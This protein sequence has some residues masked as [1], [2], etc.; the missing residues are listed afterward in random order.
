M[1]VFVNNVTAETIEFLNPDVSLVTSDRVGIANI[2]PVHTLDIGSN[3]SIY[4]NSPNILIVRGGIVA[5][6][7]VGEGPLITN[8]VMT[9]DL[10]DIM[11]RGSNAAYKI[12]FFNDTSFTTTNLAGI[13]NLYPI[14]TLD[15]GSNVFINDAIGN[16]LFIANVVDGNLYYDANLIDAN[17]TG[18]YFVNS[19][20]LY[21]DGNLDTSGNF[22]SQSNIEAP[23]F[24]G[25]GKK[26]GNVYGFA[27]LQT[28]S[29]TGN[30]TDDTVHF[31]HPMSAY[32]SIGGAGFANVNP[33]NT[34]D[35]GTKF[36]VNE[37]GPNVLVV[38]GTVIAIGFYGDGNLMTSVPST[39]ELQ[40]AS[41][42]DNT[43]TNIVQ[44]TNP[45][46]SVV[47]FANVG[48]CNTDPVHSL[49]I[50]TNCYVQDTAGVDEILMV[51]GNI[52]CN[53]FRGDGRYLS[54]IP[55][56]SE[57]STFN[58]ITNIGNTTSHTVRYVNNTTSFVTESNIGI[59][60][61]FPVHSV[62]IGTNIWMDDRTLTTL[63]TSGNIESAYIIAD[64][65]QLANLSTNLENV[66]NNGNIC[67]N[68]AFFSNTIESIV[69]ESNLKSNGDCIIDSP[70]GASVI[71]GGIKPDD[72]SSNTDRISIGSEAGQFAQATHSIA[73]GSRAGNMGQGMFSVG[74]GIQAGETHQGSNAI[75]L[76]Y[77]AG[78]EGQNNFGVAIGYRSGV[79][80]QGDYSV[81][82]GTN[83][84]V[85]EQGAN[86]VA[87]GDLSAELKQGVYS[88]IIGRGT[89]ANTQGDYS[90]AI[91]HEAANVL[92]NTSSI[93]IGIAA[94][95]S[96]QGETSIAV[97][98]TAAYSNQGSNSIAIGFAAGYSTQGNNSIA[99]GNL[100]AYLEQGSN[101]IAIGHSA[102]YSSQNNNSVAIGF[103]SGK[104]FQVEQVFAIGY[105]AGIDN[106]SQ[107]ATVIGQ[108]EGSD[109][110]DVASLSIGFKAGHTSQGANS[111]SIGTFAGESQQGIDSVAIGL[112]AGRKTQG[113]RCFAIGPKAG[114]LNQTTHSIAIGSEA[115][116]TGQAEHTIVIGSN[117]NNY[118]SN[119]ITIG[120]KGG[121]NTAN[122]ILVN[123]TGQDYTPIKSDSLY[124]T[125]VRKQFEPEIRATILSHTNNNQVIG[126]NTFYM[127]E[128]GNV[129]LSANLIVTG[130]FS[131]VSSTD[132][133]IDDNI[134]L[135]ANNNLLGS[136][137]M[138]VIMH[139][140]VS[141][142]LMGYSELGEEFLF[143][144][145]DD[146]QGVAVLTP[147]GTNMK[148]HVYGS[149]E[150]DSNMSVNYN[151]DIYKNYIGR[152]SIGYDDFHSLTPSFAH[153]DHM[154]RRNYALR[155]GSGGNTFLN[156][157]TGEKISFRKND[158]EIASIDASGITG[159]FNKILSNGYMINDNEYNGS[160][161]R[162]WDL[163]A[164]VA[165]VPGTIVVRDGT[166]I[167]YAAGDIIVN[168]N[169]TADGSIICDTSQT[170]SGGDAN[171]SGNFYSNGELVQ[172]A[173]I[174]MIVL[175]SGS[176]ASVPTY[177]SL[178]DG[179]NGTPDLRDRFVV[180]AGN[181]YAP[182]A[183]G[184]SATV[185]LTSAQIQGHTHSFSYS[186][187]TLVSSTDDGGDHTHNYLFRTEETKRRRGPY[188]CWRGTQSYPTNST[189][190]H[191]HT[192]NTTMNFNI[193]T[194]NAGSSS[195]HENR[196]PYYSLCY[197]MRTS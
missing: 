145:T 109:T 2:A 140:P 107:Y 92:Q 73:I 112:E 133:T 70:L 62:D 146:N 137:D 150:G 89:G 98:N 28:A 16:K 24:I 167:A 129:Y 144:Y 55:I 86:S 12:D 6:K 195:A 163:N 82:V 141:N 52:K 172:L 84:A 190:D 36:R 57:T 156:A 179:A 90:V 41:D 26:V 197:I 4:D 136:L 114:H 25:E 63:W 31:N 193:N 45:N 101:S 194:N 183:T 176:A 69:V 187:P 72:I 46:T 58:Y 188:S 138:G 173:P 53:Y 110:K 64:G 5:T 29:A 134:L 131:T 128:T 59:A 185:S 38:D 10:N 66:M 88:V 80:G 75:A 27:N 34:L 108:Q 22:L 77:G 7:F 76:A 85:Q 95:K 91:G 100:A 97:G 157:P 1:S 20:V 186:N 178:C 42:Y 83:V 171:I 74:L 168:G 19:N 21:V 113:E 71:I 169:I 158:V 161:A 51:S 96:N 184:G 18:N 121:V 79:V 99:A 151:T 153:L 125:P 132:F 81:S 106:T 189:G 147:K 139:R 174:G 135:L 118:V 32:F 159:H 48:I 164:N 124:F 142:V 115:A 104:N 78:N 160:V 120:Y 111:T 37:N 33:V 182:G 14:H 43:T 155:A 127:D 170:M 11:S 177:W 165:A 3:I 40:A 49:D 9:S 60:N 67:T 166:G 13:H 192:F 44:F 105:Q 196:P 154:S 87:I 30:T 23:F 93:A 130:N 94:A 54:N 65:S 50:G 119:S 126:M 117:A 15:I 116:T 191:N 180:G 149:M 17:Y 152:A 123:A 175:W 148:L 47:S 162:T 122:S 39:T 68:I 56:C 181:S 102:G 143:S 103:E 35:V 61:E 8:V